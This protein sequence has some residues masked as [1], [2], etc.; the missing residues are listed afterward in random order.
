MAQQNAYTLRLAAPSEEQTFR[1]VELPPELL[2][3]VESETSEL[4]LT[5]KGKQSDDA[6]LCSSSTTYAL[7]AVTVSN[8]FFIVQ[9][10]QLIVEDG[11]EGD[12]TLEITGQVKDIIEVHKAVPR[13][14]RL[15]GLMRGS[16]W[17]G[18]D[19]DMDDRNRRRYTYEQVS[20][21]VQASTEELGEGLREA[22][23]LHIGGKL[24]SLP[25]SQ[26]SMILEAI[27]TSLV[28][29]SLAPK[30]VP[31]DEFLDAMEEDHDL[32]RDVIRGVIAWYGDVSEE[33]WRADMASLVREIG[34]GLLTE[35]RDNPMT[36]AEFMTLWEKK[37]GDSF[38]N[39]IT[40]DLLHVRLTNRVPRLIYLT[41]SQGYFLQPE[42]PSKALVYFPHT[43]LPATPAARFADL[44]LARPRWLS[45]DMEPFLKG[46]PGG[47]SKTV[48]DALLVK[49]ARKSEAENG[50]VWWST[51]ANYT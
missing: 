41:I 46:L 10:A 14:D 28:A 6:V 8:A 7:R 29:R 47:D 36:E 27:L 4:S 32:P 16:E 33:R 48:R 1:L 38:A 12:T 20:G 34:L 30:N 11:E 50:T 44:F 45:E 25:P 15:N 19:E 18:E 31:L 26:L 40:L 17:N 37:V 42:P 35:L 5:I 49:F 22:H 43:A 2:S 3:I 13:L 9:P 39:E 51:R 23:V 24:R 21:V